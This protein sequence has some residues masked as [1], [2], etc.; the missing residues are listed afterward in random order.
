M[1]GDGDSEGY[2]L[3]RASRRTGRAAVGGCC[4]W[5]EILLQRSSCVCTRTCDVWDVCQQCVP[6]YNLK[7]CI[8]IKLNITVGNCLIV[9]SG[10]SWEDLI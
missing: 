5:Q 8:S 9:V 7:G 1:P 2:W 4:P 3:L 6:I 10:K